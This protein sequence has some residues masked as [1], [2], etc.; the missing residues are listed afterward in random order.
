MTPVDAGDWILVCGGFHAQGGMDR[1]NLA[2]TEHLLSAGAR[3]HLVAHDIEK[4]LVSRPGVTASLVPRPAGSYVAGELNLERRAH[5]LSAELRSS[6]RRPIMVANGG[7]AAGADVNWIHS[8][9]AAWPACDDDAPSWFRL[10]NR[11]TKAW[12]RRR[13]RRALSGVRVIIANSQRT[14]RDLVYAAGADPGAVHTV[15]LGSDPSWVPPDE[16]QRA[17][18]RH[19]WCADAGKPLLVFV[20]ALGYDCNKGLDTVL[21]AWPEV[22]QGWG[23]ELVVA[24][25][26]ATAIWQRRANAAG[27]GIRVL[28]HIENVGELLTAADVLISPVR[29]EAYGLAAHE[30]VCRG[31]P[32]IVSASAGVVE[33]FDPE[34]RG[35]LLDDPEDAPALAARLRMW[36]D[37]REGWRE[38]FA[39]TSS[40][41]R[42]RTWDQ[43]AGEIAILSTADVTTT[44]KWHPSPV[45]AQLR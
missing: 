20:G 15:Y 24:G 3:V 7:N 18:A 23:A 32:A 42:S 4:A 30:A 5:R 11:T 28:G 33:R 14:A 26:G 6:G 1:A 45:H 41:L 16:S 2:L 35:L 31:V 8:V 36:R 13:E 27:S 17:R 25:G 9:H 34:L 44:R 21:R 22:S 43:M 12:A 19:V 39:A 38:R 37:G 10:K 40:R 29:Y